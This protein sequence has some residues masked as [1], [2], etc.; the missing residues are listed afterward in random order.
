MLESRHS[1]W[2][3]GME[4]QR[5]R[6]VDKIVCELIDQSL[7]QRASF[8]DHVCANH[9]TL[10]KRLPMTRSSYRLRLI[11]QD[12][13]DLGVMS[14][15]LSTI[16]SIA[17]LLICAMRHSGEAAGRHTPKP[18]SE[19]AA[20]LMQVAGVYKRQFENGDVKGNKYQSEDILEVVPVDDHAAYV[21]MDL[22]FFN[23]H[24]GRIYGIAAYG[25]NS[26]IYDNGKKGDDRCVVEY[27]WSSD[28]VMT[29][30]DYDKTPGCRA[31]HG[32]RGSLDH[33]EFLVKKKQTVRYMER[34]KNSREFT[35]AMEK[36][37]YARQ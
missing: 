2:V 6:Q 10:K 34:L 33:A 19:S 36:Y 37:R 28:K 7:E 16:T 4:G 24:S 15:R 17:V 35:E 23:G 25:E 9:A 18:I 31:Y 11:S 3:L 20:F 21:R 22:K 14:K 26:L 8:L 12:L 27:V 29:R 30:A 32:A 1:N 5:W 13:A